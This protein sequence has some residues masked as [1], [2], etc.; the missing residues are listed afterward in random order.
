MGFLD[1]SGDIIL[2]CGP[3]G[4]RE[5]KTSPWRN[6]SFKIVKF[7]LGDDEIDYSL[8]RNSNSSEGVHPSG[9]AYY[10]L[11]ILQTP[12]LEAFTNN[13]SVLKSKLISYAQND[14]LY[15]PVIKL[16]NILFKTANSQTLWTTPSL[17]IPDGGYIVTADKTT[18]DEFVSNEN[19]DW[20]IGL[21][22]GDSLSTQNAFTSKPLVFDQGLDTNDLNVGYL[23]DNDARV[24][25]NSL[26]FRTG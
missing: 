16:N 6:G 24:E 15:L 4:H 20:S 11:N 22:K 25:R 2:G 1:N 13:A 10:D 12:I 8:Y 23:V 18:S 14:L 21:I 3:N 5:K 7:A 19:Q 9:S 17:T 26:H